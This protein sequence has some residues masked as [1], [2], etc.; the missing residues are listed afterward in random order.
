M[1]EFE[2]LTDR[3]FAL[4]ADNAFEEAALEVF[5]FQYAHNVVYRR[6]CDLLGQTPAGIR[7]IEQI[8]FLPVE[9]FKSHR[10]VSFSSPETHVFT[11]SATTGSV[12]ARHF[13]TDLTVYERSFMEGFRLFY[14]LPS[15]YCVLALL[16]GYLERKGSSLVY[17]A[18]RLIRES[19]HPD[20]GFYLD[21]LDGLAL[22]LKQLME[23]G[24]RILLMGVS[25]ALLDFAEKHPMPLHNTIV[26]ETGGMKGRRREMTRQELHERLRKAFQQNAI[27]SEYGMTEL[28]SQAY[29]MGSGRFECPSWMRVLIRDSNDPLEVSA[30]LRGGKANQQ[31]SVTGRNEGAVNQHETGTSRHE[32]V[33]NPYEDSASRQE[34]VHRIRSGGI[35]VVDLANIQSCSFLGTEDLGRLH[36]DGTFEVLGRFDHSE[37]RGCNLM[38]QL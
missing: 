6:Y 2:Q 15:R 33:V 28:F 4:S 5:R 34:N 32:G 29:S 22:R 26:M 3:I 23:S 31:D 16:P 38:A 11:S 30:G 27:H 19:G 37:V 18:D 9:L 17:M 8:P 25:F 12:P 36:H 10:V 21:N 14:G 20:S 24:T 35:N 1:S 7:R 13:V